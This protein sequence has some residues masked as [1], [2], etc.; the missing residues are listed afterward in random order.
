MPFAQRCFLRYEIQLS[1]VGDTCGKS[2]NDVNS[3]IASF[4]VFFIILKF[5]VLVAINFGKFFLCT[6]YVEKQWIFVV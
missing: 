3:P 1:S 5:I 6:K 4:L 2:G